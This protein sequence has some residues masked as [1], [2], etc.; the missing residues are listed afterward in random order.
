MSHLPPRKVASGRCFGRGGVRAMPTGRV[1]M[2]LASFVLLRLS[3][4]FQLFILQLIP[5]F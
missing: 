3:V 1:F 2:I 4:H 5:S